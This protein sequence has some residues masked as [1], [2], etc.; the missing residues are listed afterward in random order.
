MKK[1][2]QTSDE[3]HWLATAKHFALTFGFL[4]PENSELSY[5]RK[6]GCFGYIG[7]YTAQFCGDYKNH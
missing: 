3:V 5:E 2:F 1:L 4:G 6:T 7:D